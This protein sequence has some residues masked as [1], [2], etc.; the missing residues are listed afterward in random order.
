[1]VTCHPPLPVWLK[2]NNHLRSFMNND[3]YHGFT[4]VRLTDYLALTRLWLS[5]RY[6]SRDL[7]PTLR[8]WY[9]VR[10]ALYSDPW[11]CLMA[12]AVTAGTSFLR[13]DSFISQLR[14]ARLISYWKRLLSSYKILCYPR[15]AEQH[16]MQPVV[17]SNDKRSGLFLLLFLG[18]LA[19]PMR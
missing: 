9:I 15:N 4:Y 3:L 17:G 14:V 6:A 16:N 18:I 1:M 12:Q 7:H 19:L 10:V 5:G 11:V 13:S 8:Y 2:R